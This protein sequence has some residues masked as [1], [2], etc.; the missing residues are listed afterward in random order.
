VTANLVP[1]QKPNKKKSNETRQNNPQSKRLNN[2][3]RKFTGDNIIV[4]F[5]SVPSGKS[6]CAPLDSSSRLTSGIAC[7]SGFVN[8]SDKGVKT[9]MLMSTNLF[10]ASLCTH[11]E[12]HIIVGNKKKRNSML[13]E[14]ACKEDEVM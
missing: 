14:L 7:G 11:L 9:P 1:A 10:S 2:I 8:C 4:Q 6:L 5:K 3:A 12:T 13:S